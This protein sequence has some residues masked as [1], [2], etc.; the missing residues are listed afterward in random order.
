MQSERTTTG[1]L[2]IDGR[3]LD[4]GINLDAF[5]WVNRLA[6]HTPCQHVILVLASR[7]TDRRFPSDHATMAGA[8]AIGL[9]LAGR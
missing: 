1:N 3:H 9:F 7:S 4:P 5:L 2:R 8:V 6:R